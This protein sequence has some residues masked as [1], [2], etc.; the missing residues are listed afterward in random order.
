MFNLNLHMPSIKKKVYMAFN[1]KTT[2]VIQASQW[3]VDSEHVW[4]MV[5]VTKWQ[6]SPG[7]VNITDLLHVRNKRVSYFVMCELIVKGFVTIKAI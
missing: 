2:E 4:I 1:N 3:L 5:I 7:T 6:S